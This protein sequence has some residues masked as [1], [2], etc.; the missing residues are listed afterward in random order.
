MRL[1][2]LIAILLTNLSLACGEET[3]SP[4]AAD[5]FVELFNGKTLDGWTVATCEV[6]IEN[7]ALKLV[8]GNGMVRTNKKY[9]DYI[10]DY[11]WK[12]LAKENW[13]S[14]IYFRCKLPPADSKR[15]WP[16]YYQANLLK[17]MEGNV[18]RLK[19]AKSSGLV[20]PGEWNRFKLTVKGTKAELEINGQPAWK[21]DGLEDPDG[22]IAIQAEVPK[23]GQ[24][25]FRNV[26]IKELK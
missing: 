4:A 9:A 15:P 1:L 10:L 25:L 8:S 22:Y 7:G 26:R 12:A 18:N 13:D 24:F 16:H 23:G 2:C 20:K 5:G 11:E 3:K 21:A 17:G 6:V 14:G 19:G